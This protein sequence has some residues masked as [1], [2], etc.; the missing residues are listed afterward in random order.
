M[1]DVS[2]GRGMPRPRRRAVARR[3][4]RLALS[5][6]RCDVALDESERAVEL[7]QDREFPWAMHQFWE[8]V[9]DTATGA[10]QPSI[11]EQARAHADQARV[12]SNQVP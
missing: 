9:G 11:A 4:A 10:G 5:E 1:G 2:G 12:K 3:R 6:G 8:F 7:F